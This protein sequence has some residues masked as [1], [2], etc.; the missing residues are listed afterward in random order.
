MMLIS[1]KKSISKNHFFFMNDL[2]DIVHCGR[3]GTIFTELTHYKNHYIKMN[4]LSN[5][6]HYSA[7]MIYC[8]TFGGACDPQV[9]DGG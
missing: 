9:V 6:M 8:V 7:N 4:D 1:P 5:I 3:D 2:S